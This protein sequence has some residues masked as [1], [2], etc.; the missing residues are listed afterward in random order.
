MDILIGLLVA[1]IILAICFSFGA[2]V[3][4]ATQNLWNSATGNQRGDE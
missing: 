2:A 1:V 3:R 4:T